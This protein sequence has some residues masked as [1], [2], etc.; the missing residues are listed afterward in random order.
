[1]PRFAP[2]I[3]SE[4]SKVVASCASGNDAPTTRTF[5]VDMLLEDA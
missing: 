3:L 1:M 5:L 4:A 2:A